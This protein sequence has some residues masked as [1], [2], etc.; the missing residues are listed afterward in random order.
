M[1]EGIKL[2]LFTNYVPPELLGYSV[3][4]LNLV[5]NFLHIHCSGCG[6]TFTPFD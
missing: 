3:I 4:Y 5:I 2:Y 1:T 6:K